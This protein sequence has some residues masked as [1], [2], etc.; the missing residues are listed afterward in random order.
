MNENEILFDLKL[1]KD[2]LKKVRQIHIVACGT[3]MHAGLNGK[4]II[5]KLTRIPVNVEVAS[6]FRYKEPILLKND[7]AIFISQ[8]G[9]TA[10]TIACLE[11]IKEKKIK[12]ISMVNVKESTIDRLC[13]N[14]L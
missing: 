8:S 13:E 11:L 4:N 7:L 14:V 6:E 2:D 12:H 9:E 3:A 5:E 10:D 1:T